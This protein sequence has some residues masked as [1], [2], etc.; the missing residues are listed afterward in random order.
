MT[1]DERETI[2]LILTG[3]ENLN[4][5]CRMLHARINTLE[6]WRA[7]QDTPVELIQ[8]ASHDVPGA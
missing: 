2:N 7:Q 1:P 8:E 6:T 3:I 5:S 4:E